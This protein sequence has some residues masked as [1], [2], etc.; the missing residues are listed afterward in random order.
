[1][2]RG[3]WPHNCHVTITLTRT[4]IQQLFLREQAEGHA[5]RKRGLGL[6]RKG[7]GGRGGSKEEDDG[8]D[9]RGTQ[10]VHF[11]AYI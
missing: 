9:G 2:C 8:R 3:G 5:R 4:F 7:G 10:Y 6:G 11:I 1:M